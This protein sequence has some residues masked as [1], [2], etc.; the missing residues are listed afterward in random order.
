MK[1]QIGT[2]A[3]LAFSLAGCGGAPPSSPPAD[4]EVDES[5]LEF[6]MPSEPLTPETP[7]TEA[8]TGDEAPAADESVDSPNAESPEAD[9]ADTAAP[10]GSDS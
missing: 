4:L 9:S 7:S 1:M 3:L 8:P 5:S 2:I 10:S 6:E